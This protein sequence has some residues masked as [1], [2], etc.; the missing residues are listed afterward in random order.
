MFQFSVY[1]AAFLMMVTLV[2]AVAFEGLR[3]A[4]PVHLFWNIISGLSNRLLEVLAHEHYLRSHLLDLLTELFAIERKWCTNQYPMKMTGVYILFGLARKHRSPARNPCTCLS[5]AANCAERVRYLDKDRKWDCGLDALI[6]RG[7]SGRDS[8]GE[9][10]RY[11][12]M[13][14]MGIV[15][16]IGD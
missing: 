2:E 9:V 11:E 3:I 16:L 5:P 8:M 4:L 13:E 12:G 1:N 10:K 7:V 14:T 15:T 6:M